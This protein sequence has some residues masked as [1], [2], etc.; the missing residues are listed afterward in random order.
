MK[1]QSNCSLR[2]LLVVAICCSAVSIAHADN[3][4][5]WLTGQAAVSGAVGFG[6]SGG[7]FG[8]GFMDMSIFGP[9]LLNGSISWDANLVGYGQGY[10]C[11]NPPGCTTWEIDYSAGMRGG[12]FAMTVNRGSQ[13]LQFTGSVTNGG[14]DGGYGEQDI[15][16]GVRGSWWQFDVVTFKGA[17]SNGWT[18]SGGFYAQPSYHCCGVVEGEFFMTTTAPEPGG[19][20][21]FSSGILCLAGV[22]GRKLIL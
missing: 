2:I 5:P 4:V 6:D 21:L 9:D 8:S 7:G 10:I 3:T 17:W 12:A 22:L 14:L 20:A 13:V 18:G 15:G 19:I 1:S 11:Y 16:I